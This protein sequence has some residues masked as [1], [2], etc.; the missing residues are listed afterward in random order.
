MVKCG[1]K[2]CK[3]SEICD[4]VEKRCVT[5]SRQ[6]FSKSKLN[7][8]QL[9]SGLDVSMPLPTKKRKT[10]PR[11]KKD[12]TYYPL[13]WEKKPGEVG[14][15]NYFKGEIVKANL[16]FDI[17]CDFTP[18]ELKLQSYQTL[19]KWAMHPRSVIKR[20]LVQWQLGAGKTIGMIQVL[21]NYFDDPRPKLLLFPNKEVCNN[22]YNE[23]ARQPNKYKSWYENGH[24]AKYPGEVRDSDDARTRELK[25][26]WLQNFK[27]MLAMKSQNNNTQSSLA[28]PLVAERYSLAGGKTFLNGGRWVNWKGR[29]LVKGNTANFNSCIILCDE[30]HN[31][32]IP[33]PSFHH[34]QSPNA[35]ECGKRLTAAKNSV[36]AFFT[37]T[38]IVKNPEDFIKVMRMVIGTENNSNNMFLHTAKENRI[39]EGENK[40]ITVIK[41]KEGELEGYLSSYLQRPIKVFAQAIPSGDDIPNVIRCELQGWNL[42]HYIVTRFLK[43]KEPKSIPVCN[44][45]QILNEKTNKCVKKS[46]KAGKKLM[47]EKAEGNIK[48]TKDGIPNLTYSFHCLQHNALNKS[49]KIC[50]KTLQQYEHSF[51]YNKNSPPMYK[52]KIKDINS[53][54]DMN[55]VESASKLAS[56]ALSIKSYKG[57]KAKTC[58][59]IHKAN[60]FA[61]LAKLFDF[62][63]INY[64]A[65]EVKKS[66]DSSYQNKNREARN[67]AL[68]SKFNDHQN[69]KR[70]ENIQVILLTAD[71]F[72][73]GISLFNCRRIILADL[74]INKEKASWALVKQRLGRALRLCGHKNLPEIERTL[75]IDLFVSTM[76]HYSTIKYVLPQM[77]N[78][79]CEFLAST[80]T[81]EEMKLTDVIQQQEEIES[82]MRFV[83]QCAIDYNLY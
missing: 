71:E 43:G 82:A 80:K 36:I 40:E 6:R 10:I 19:L 61:I 69:N 14:F 35:I 23:L 81:L 70:G 8:M 60:G 63:K 49:N 28:S 58:V 44:D 1:R 11:K 45:D 62:M 56:I 34:N 17:T 30:A 13:T 31:M 33:N 72:S 79:Q 4:P 50:K 26:D 9:R 29:N 15:N 24:G 55:Y 64:A 27:D 16:Q 75:E 59:L 2:I 77:T 18:G 52:D 54:T 67:D 74:S 78:D 68:I 83:G 25:K 21:D 32:V 65:I 73:E 47:K 5:P 51:F 76:P 66:T 38:P 42:R 22:F 53:F 48:V 37:A 46:G 3:P 39:I 7:K 12:N 41:T 57:G 20:L